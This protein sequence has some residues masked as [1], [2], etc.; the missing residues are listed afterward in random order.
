MI[1]LCTACS[2]LNRIKDRSSHDAKCGHCSK[3]LNLGETVADVDV[4]TL[5]H[6]VK[7]SPVPVVVDFWAPWCGPCV[8]FAPVYKDFS[9]KYAQDALYLKIDTEAHQ[10]AG[11]S[12]NIRG[13]PTLVLFKEGKE[14]ARQSGAMPMA[15]LKQWVEGQGVKLSLARDF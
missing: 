15:M 11:S 7:N 14:H 5:L 8:S 1:K 9:N 2:G 12:F 13:I 4:A 10:D 3:P 6:V